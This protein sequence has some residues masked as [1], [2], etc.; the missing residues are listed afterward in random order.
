MKVT[1][2]PTSIRLVYI[3]V[4]SPRTDYR[5]VGEIYRTARRRN[6]LCGITG[7]LVFDGSRFCSLLHGPEQA[8]ADLRSTIEADERNV[9]FRVVFD[10]RQSQPDPLPEMP[11]WRSG[12]LESDVI[13]RIEGLHNP[14]PA[15]IVSEIENVARCADLDDWPV[16]RLSA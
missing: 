3:S 4:L 8:V 2:P 10:S 16:A 13:D 12:Y 6:A 5:T 15:A 9:D 1:A 7:F 11:R 14:G